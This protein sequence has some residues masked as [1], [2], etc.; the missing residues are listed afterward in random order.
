MK[1][2]S[3]MLLNIILLT[4]ISASFFLVN[5]TASN[6][7]TTST[8]EYDPWCDLND[9]GIIDIYDVVMVCV[10]FG[11]EG[12]PINKTELLLSLNQTVHELQSKMEVRIPKKGYLPI[13]PKG[14]VPE[15]EA[16]DYYI[17]DKYLYGDGRFYTN[18]QLPNGVILT[19]MTV[20]LTDSKDDGHVE[21]WISGWNLTKDHYVTLYPQ[22]YVATTHEATPGATVLY[23]DTIDEPQIDS[24]NCCYSLTVSFTYKDILLNL[25]GVIIEYEY[26]Q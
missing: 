21:A 6:Y 12:T 8:H 22:A 11:S 10:R 5:T 16:N 15:N 7:E 2:T 1:I 26:P 3:S 13:G 20:F 17:S 24:R 19:N 14:F 18:L 4:I 25:F 9:D 23:D